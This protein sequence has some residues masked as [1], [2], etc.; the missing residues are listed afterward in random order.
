MNLIYAVVFMMTNGTLQ[1]LP[2]NEGWLLAEPT[3]ADCQSLAMQMNTSPNIA[4]HG[5]HMVCLPIK[6]RS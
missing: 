5:G 1:A 6:V 3:L 2:Q 4:L